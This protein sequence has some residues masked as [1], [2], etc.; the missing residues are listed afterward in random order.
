MKSIQHC[1]HCQLQEK[2]DVKN[3]PHK[4]IGPMPRAPQKA[5]KGC[6]PILL[7]LVKIEKINN[8]ETSPSLLVTT[9]ELVPVTLRPSLFQATWAA[10]WARTLQVI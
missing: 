6:E 4:C 1:L 5:G 3:P 8:L 2:I 7:N 9:P 10:G